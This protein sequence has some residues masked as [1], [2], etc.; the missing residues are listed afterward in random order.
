M[1]GRW[2]TDGGSNLFKIESE[3]F[4]DKRSTN[5][6]IEVWLYQESLKLFVQESKYELSHNLFRGGGE[7]GMSGIQVI[8]LGNIES[9]V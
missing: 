8:F 4:S 6:P 1:S 3:M 9:D 7:S 5:K 2:R